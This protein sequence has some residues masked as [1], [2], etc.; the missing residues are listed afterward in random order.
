MTTEV[1]IPARV[2][3]TEQPGDPP[4]SSN[5]G[6]VYT[7]DNGGVTALYFEDDAGTVTQI[8]GAGGAAGVSGTGASTRV[9]FWSGASALSSDATFVFDPAAGLTAGAADAVTNTVTNVLTLNH[10]TSGTPA[11]SYA[12]GVLLRGQ[13]ASKTAGGD[14][15]ARVAA[16]WTTATAA[17]EASAFSVGLRA[18]GAAIPAVG[19]EQFQVSA[20]GVISMVQGANTHTIGP[21]V[22]NAGSLSIIPNSD[23]LGIRMG[24]GAGYLAVYNS[25]STTFVDA[26]ASATKIAFRIGSTTYIDFTSSLLTLADPLNIVLGT[27]TGTKIGTA[28][29]QKLG[30]FNATPIVQPTVTGSRGGNAA[31]ASLLTQLA[32]LGLVVDSSS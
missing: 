15:M 17:S 10:T 26:I 25:G 12:V 18:A 14:D 8:T 1:L 9:A 23:S 20:L 21:Y 32:S 27:T 13:D 6:F 11:S 22:S 30:F 4:A 5:N 3:L 16:R 2:L 19:S 28:T 7:K 29:T 24:S 31:L